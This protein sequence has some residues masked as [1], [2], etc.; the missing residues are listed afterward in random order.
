MALCKSESVIMDEP[1]R[2]IDVGAKF[3]YNIMN[4]LVAT[5]RL[6]G[7]LRSCRNTWDKR[8]LLCHGGRDHNGRTFG[9]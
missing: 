7:Y 1:T 9:K 8:R 2:G 4:Q 3:G 6:S 5:I